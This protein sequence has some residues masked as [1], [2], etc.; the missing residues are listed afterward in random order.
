MR[1]P[2]EE[3]DFA[4]PDPA[5]AARISDAVRMPWLPENSCLAPDDDAEKDRA[6]PRPACAIAAGPVAIVKAKHSKINCLQAML[7]VKKP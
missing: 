5:S 2:P 7:T 4:D 3:K 1:H 6:R